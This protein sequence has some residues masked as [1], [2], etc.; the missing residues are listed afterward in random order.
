MLIC[1]KYH[2]SSIFAQV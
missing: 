2:R 1:T